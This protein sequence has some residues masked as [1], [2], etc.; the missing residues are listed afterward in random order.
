MRA[1][2]VVIELNAHIYAAPAWVLEYLYVF[3]R[4]YC[5][6]GAI[7]VDLERRGAGALIAYNELQ[8]PFEL[9]ARARLRGRDYAY[10]I[11][12]C[13]SVL[14]LWRP[15]SEICGQTSLRVRRLGRSSLPS[16]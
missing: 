10:S 9:Q 11:A 7:A 2:E 8:A 12:H 3:L 6:S 1:V 15:R 14:R 16:P 13:R 5:Y 4:L